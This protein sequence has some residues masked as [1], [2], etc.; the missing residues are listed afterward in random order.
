MKRMSEE[1]KEY[2]TDVFEVCNKEGWECEGLEEGGENIVG[3]G[4]INAS[5]VADL[6]VESY[7]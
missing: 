1:V 3:E 6:T 7:T 4:L 2:I 5:R